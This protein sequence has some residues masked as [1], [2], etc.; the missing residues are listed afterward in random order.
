MMMINTIHGELPIDTLTVKEVSS[1][2]PDGF[3]TATEYYQG[4]ELVRRDVHV[5]VKAHAVNTIQAQEI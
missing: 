5:A 2:A 4:D 3:V 1:D